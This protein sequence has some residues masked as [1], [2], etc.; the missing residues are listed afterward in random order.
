MKIKVA[1]LEKDKSY[2]NRL[3]TAFGAKYADKFEVYS[4]TD[5]EI[6]LQTIREIKTDVLIAGEIFDIDLAQIPKRCGFAYLV[7]SPDIDT[8]SGQR[9]IC[10]F[11]KADLIYK[12]RRL[13]KQREVK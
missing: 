10:K 4:F 1:V 6:A 11:Q 13:C 8:L 9:T 2:L 5:P 7:D 12:V 3:V